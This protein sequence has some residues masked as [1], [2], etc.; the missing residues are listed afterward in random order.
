F[1]P[2]ELVTLALNGE[3]LATT[4]IRTS[5][6]GSF[7]ATVTA[8]DRLLP[9]ANT[10]SV[11]GATSRRVALATVRGRRSTQTYY[12]AGGVESRTEHAALDLLNTSAQRTHVGY[13]L[14]SQTGDTTRGTLTVGAHAARV[15]PLAGLTH[16]RGSFGVALR[17]DRPLAAQL[18][19]TRQGRDGDTILAAPGT[20]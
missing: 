13:T 11:V 6:L 4:T 20:A 19:L 9:G 10:V 18:T 7:T 3:A 12:L 2:N 15:V 5:G 8:P 1:G 17:T 16:L 14:Y